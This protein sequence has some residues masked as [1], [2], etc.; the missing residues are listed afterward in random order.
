MYRISICSINLDHHERE[1]SLDHLAEDKKYFSRVPTKCTN[2]W[3]KEK[4]MLQRGDTTIHI[5]RWCASKEGYVVL[6]VRQQG[7]SA[8]CVVGKT[9]RL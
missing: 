4:H 8:L 7:Y 2:T 6:L 5:Q 1:P 9:T 3:L